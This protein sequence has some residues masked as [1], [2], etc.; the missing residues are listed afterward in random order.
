MTQ[1]NGS[2]SN[3]NGN[4]KGGGALVTQSPSQAEKRL[5]VY[6][7][8]PLVF[9]Q[10][11]IL[12]QSPWT[13]RF[14]LWAIVSISTFGI[15]WSCLA[16][17]EEAVPAQGKLEPQG[18]V[19]EVQ[20]PVGGVVSEIKVEEGD[21]VK[22]GQELIRFDQTTSQAQDDSLR[23][24]LASL[25]AETAFYRAQMNRVEAVPSRVYD[26]P[27]TVPDELF[28]LTDNRAALVSENL[29]F[30]AQLGES[31]SAALSADQLQRLRS[32]QAE[33]NSRVAAAELEVQ[34]LDRQLNQVRVQL[35]S[36][37]KNLATNQEI[38]DGIQPLMEEGGVARV[39]F[40]R[41]E[42]EVQT[43]QSEVN[44]LLQEEQRLLLDISQAQEE[45]QNTIAASDDDLYRRIADNDK[46]ISE[47]D[48]QLNKLIVENQKQIDEI[49]SQMSQT[50][51]T[52]QY[53]ILTAPVDGQVF[54]LKPTGPGF[55]ANTTEPVL[56]IVPNDGQLVA[57]VFITNRDIGF[58]SPDQD[59]DVRIDSFPYSEFGDVKGKLVKIGS[60][61]LPPDEIYQFYRFPA[62]VA[63][64]EQQIVINGKPI[65]LQSGMS[66]SVNI[67]T[68]PRRVITFL[69]DLFVRKVDS[70]RT[71]R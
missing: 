38:L 59:V 8:A 43:L 27:D 6:N 4:G 44:R 18:A 16:K 3:G 7:Q 45:L 31:S 22:A 67:K 47:I 32:A 42:Q 71:S 65:E 17:V 5:S 19:K 13:S 14:I 57:R 37:R 26:V 62:E 15:A 54:D 10:P 49:R 9:E 1:S 51:Q 33:K 40:L 58:V 2:Y 48:S 68:R 46:R 55:V 50:A 41:Q 28:Y 21:E 34:Q 29:Y 56:K 25:E 23:Q 70:V 64:N 11:V 35:E 12:R 20:A 36:N 53:Q 30:R 60:D 52:L 66:V 63:L 24:I 39:Q 61:A 69:T